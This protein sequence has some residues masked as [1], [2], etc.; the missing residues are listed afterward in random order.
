MKVNGR[1]GLEN[2]FYEVKEENALHALNH[3]IAL[4]NANTNNFVKFILPLC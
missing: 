4:L 2:E 1:T 3:N